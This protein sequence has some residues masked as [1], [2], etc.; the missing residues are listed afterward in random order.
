MQQWYHL[1]AYWKL[2]EADLHDVY[3]IDC[4]DSALMA[5]RSWRWLRTRVDG[6]LTMPPTVAVFPTH[7]QIIPATRVGFALNPPEPPEA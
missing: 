7:T 4:G 5:A 1:L 6:L 3:G 2:I